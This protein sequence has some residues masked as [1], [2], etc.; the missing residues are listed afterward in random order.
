[1]TYSSLNTVSK[2]DSPKD[3]FKTLQNLVVH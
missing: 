3:P 2:I 1:M